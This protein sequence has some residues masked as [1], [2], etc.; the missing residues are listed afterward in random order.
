MRAHRTPRVYLIPGGIHES[1]TNLIKTHIP[2]LYHKTKK[3]EEGKRPIG[4]LVDA[5]DDRISAD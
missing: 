5:I 3:N 2:T 1:Q 4:W